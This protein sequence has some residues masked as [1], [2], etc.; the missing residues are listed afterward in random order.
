[1]QQLNEHDLFTGPGAPSIPA[2]TPPGRPTRRVRTATIVAL[3]VLLAVVFG[4]GLFA[5]WVFS[6]RSS[7][8]ASPAPL[9]Q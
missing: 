3:V 2:V 7:G 6:S 9:L 5:G 8:G 1:M 4:I